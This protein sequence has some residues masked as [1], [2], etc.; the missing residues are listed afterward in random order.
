MSRKKEGR[1]RC[2]IVGCGDSDRDRSKHLVPQEPELRKIWLRL[3]GLTPS[4]ARRYIYV[5]GRRHFAN[6]AYSINPNLMQTMGF[7]RKQQLRFDAVPA[8]HLPMV[9]VSSL[10]LSPLGKQIYITCVC[11]RAC[12]YV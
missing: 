10:K 9:Q 1:K 6:E 11:A 3:I 2:S 7:G 5:C 4:D 8:L 12:V